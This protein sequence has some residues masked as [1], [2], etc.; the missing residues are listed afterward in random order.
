MNIPSIL[1][2]TPHLPLVS[3]MMM[4]EAVAMANG[5]YLTTLDKKDFKESQTFVG[6]TQQLTLELISKEDGEVKVTFINKSTV[7]KTPEEDDD[8][9]DN[10]IID[11]P[12]YR[13]EEYTPWLDTPV[14][15]QSKEELSFLDSLGDA[16]VYPVSGNNNDLAF[17]LSTLLNSYQFAGRWIS[18][19]LGG[20]AAGG[21]E[22]LYRGPSET[23]PKEFLVD[24]SPLVAIIQIHH[25][26]NKGFLCLRT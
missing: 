6:P 1:E 20:Y 17:Q 24:P 2:G 16:G 13:P 22:L 5:F 14:T 21:F 25:G 10:W 9:D 19:T 23:A 18:G 15:L 12:I 3:G 4:E 26:D 11:N 7:D 8:S